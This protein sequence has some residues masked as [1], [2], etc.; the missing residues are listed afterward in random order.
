MK[1]KPILQM[2]AEVLLAGF[3]NYTTWPEPLENVLTYRRTGMSRQE[4]RRA[5]D[6]LAETGKIRL[7]IQDMMDCAVK[8]PTVVFFLTDGGI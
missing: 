1:P 5:M 7:E 4:A 6:F 2:Q 3:R 8:K